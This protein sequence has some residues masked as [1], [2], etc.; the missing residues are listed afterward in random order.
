[1]SEA[2]KAIRAAYY[3]AGR[4]QPADYPKLPSWESLPIELREVHVY[5]AGRTAALEGRKRRATKI[6]VPLSMLRQS[7][8]SVCA[9]CS[10]YSDRGAEPRQ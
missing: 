9:C 6:P 8:T 3:E 5:H 7:T 4:L 1:M 10:C 2:L